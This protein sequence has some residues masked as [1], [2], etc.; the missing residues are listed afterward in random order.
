[1]KRTASISIRFDNFC[2]LDCVL[3]IVE[4]PTT[5]TESN[6]DYIAI[7]DKFRLGTANEPHV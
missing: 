3:A 1:M 7:V 6:Y 4:Q 5:T 2:E